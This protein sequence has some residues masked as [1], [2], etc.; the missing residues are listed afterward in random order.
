MDDVIS[1]GCSTSPP[2]RS[3]VH[4]QPCSICC[5]FV[6]HRVVTVFWCQP[7]SIVGLWMHARSAV[8]LA[9]DLDCRENCTTQVGM[10]RSPSLAPRAELHRPAPHTIW[11]IADKWHENTHTRRPSCDT[12]CYADSGTGQCSQHHWQISS[13]RTLHFGDNA[14]LQAG[15]VTVGLA[16]RWPRVTD[17]P[18]DQ[19]RAIHGL[20]I[21]LTSPRTRLRRPL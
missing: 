14:A 19:I 11:N 7:V 13:R 2:S 9:T 3:A 4:T 18:I 20:E 21:K 10:S 17:L 5:G 15:K 8:C 12:H 6:V 1:Q 16:L